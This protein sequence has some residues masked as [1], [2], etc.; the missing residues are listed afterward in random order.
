VAAAPPTTRSPRKATGAGT[1]SLATTATTS[2]AEAQPG[3][4]TVDIATQGTMTIRS[5]LVGPPPSARSDVPL[6]PHYRR[7]ARR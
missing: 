4:T 7:T 1:A 3:P 5:T 2:V 6:Q